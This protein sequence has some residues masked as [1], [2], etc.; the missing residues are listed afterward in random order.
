VIRRCPTRLTILSVALA[1]GSGL[2]PAY[3]LADG[4][5]NYN[6]TTTSA[7]SSPSGPPPGTP[8]VTLNSTLSNGST[9][10]SMPSTNGLGVGYQVTGTGIPSGT[11]ISQISSD[12]SQVTLNQ[13][14]TVSG[15]ESL[16]FTP[17]I[18]PPQIIALIEPAGG[19]IT[20]PSSSALGPLTILS[21]SQGF[22][23]SGV[24]DY[25]A[26]TKDANG[27]PLQAIGLS[28][29]GQGLSSLANGGILKFSLDVADQSA[30]PQ[31]VSQTPGVSI[32]LQPAASTSGSGD[33][34]TGAGGGTTVITESV[35]E[36]LS[37]LVWSALAGA[38]L[39]RSRVLRKPRAGATKG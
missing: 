22:N 15:G 28:F 11:T 4:I 20:P 2:Q 36:P 32:T 35:P 30:P 27:N 8:S 18:V 9:T 1:I 31:L 14:A 38:G 13:G 7:L 3:T 6:L 16:M 34:N 24:Y 25:L 12:G 29:Y 17:T 21:G 19:V 37:I 5:A 26:S 33:T 10:V 39:L 23:S